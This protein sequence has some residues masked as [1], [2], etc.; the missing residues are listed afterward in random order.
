MWWLVSVM[1]V[2]T[3]AGVA[4]WPGA[5]KTSLFGWIAALY[6]SSELWCCKL[7]HA[8]VVCS[9][10]PDA[11]CCVAMYTICVGSFVALLA[12]HGDW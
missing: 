1:L 5:Y 12:L 9:K 6:A 3:L 7:G 11:Q 4:H 2:D 8:A 10:A